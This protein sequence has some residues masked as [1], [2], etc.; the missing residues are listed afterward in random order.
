MIRL[1]TLTLFVSLSLL[2]ADRVVLT[3]GDIVTGTIV[4]K[5]GAKLTIKSDL[6]GPVTM[7]WSAVKSIT[8]DSELF[9]ELPGGDTVKGKLATAADRLEIA[10]P[11]ETRSAPIAQIIAVRD[12]AEQH[13]FERLEHPGL[14]D[15]WNGYFDIGLALARGNARTDTLT[16]A[17]NAARATRADKTSV[18][19]NQIYGTARVNNLTSTIASAVR[20]GWRYD[21]NFGSRFFLNAMNDYEHDRF[22]NLDLRFV[23]GTGAGY[24]AVKHDGFTLDVDGGADYA[25]ENYLDSLRHNLAEAN[26]GDTLAYRLNGSTSLTQ[27]FRMFNNLSDTGQYRVNSDLGMVTVVR[28]WLGWHVTAS[29]RYISNPAEGRQRNDLLISTGFRLSFAR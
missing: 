28:K 11:G 5:D 26:F 2:A 12:D 15:L 22:Q 1:F 19:F 27:A 9:V 23:V 29:D 24:H 13:A 18:Y 14:L 17:F 4:K 7:P 25:R 10:I 3:N 21:R 6:M 16:T 8:S 20:G